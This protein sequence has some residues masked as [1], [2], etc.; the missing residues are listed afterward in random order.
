MTDMTITV[1]PTASS[2][3]V[4]FGI[5]VGIGVLFG[6]LPAKRAASLNPIE[7]LRYD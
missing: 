6:Y 2:I 1:I 5:S 7:A 4:A 3:A